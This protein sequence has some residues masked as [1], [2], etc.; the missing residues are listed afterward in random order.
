MVSIEIPSCCEYVGRH[1]APP[2]FRTVPRE[3]GAIDSE[4]SMPFLLITLQPG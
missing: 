1:P 4:T 2:V 3:L